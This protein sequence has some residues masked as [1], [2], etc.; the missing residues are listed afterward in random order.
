[1]L[2]TETVF[3]A[4]AT[5]SPRA[6]ASSWDWTVQARRGLMMKNGWVRRSWNPLKINFTNVHWNFLPQDTSF[7]TTT[8][9][10][11]TQKVLLEKASKVFQFLFSVS[12]IVALSLMLAHRCHGYDF[13]RA[14][15]LDTLEHH[16]N[17]PIHS[18]YTRRK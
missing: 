6:L 4:A 18:Y 17:I 9:P 12:L 1:M 13:F 11:Q 16:F 2:V 3:I 10:K 5:R 14:Y 8:Q 7:N 15:I